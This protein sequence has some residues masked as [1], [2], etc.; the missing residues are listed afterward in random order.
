M[1]CR[2]SVHAPAEALAMLLNDS[3]S[4]VREIAARHPRVPMS[5]VD[6]PLDAREAAAS[7]DHAPAEVLIAL[8]ADD[9]SSVHASEPS[10]PPIDIA[11]S[12]L[13]ISSG[14]TSKP[15]KCRRGITPSSAVP[16]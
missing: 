2:R 7:S 16:L 3:E 11:A 5:I 4:Y 9:A 13:P 1:P 6:A 10:S 12:R 14:S 8:A 15:Q